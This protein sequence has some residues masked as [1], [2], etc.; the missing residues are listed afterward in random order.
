MG[1]NLNFSKANKVSRILLYFCRY[2]T[3]PDHA[4]LIGPKIQPRY[5]SARS[6]CL[7]SVFILNQNSTE[8]DLSD[9]DWQ[10]VKVND[11]MTQFEM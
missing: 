6:K 9:G 2:E 4:D 11:E 1:H 8:Y 7:L 3:G 5:N 10:Q